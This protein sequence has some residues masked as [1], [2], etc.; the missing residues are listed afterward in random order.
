MAHPY[1][2]AVLS[3]RYHPVVVSSRTKPRIFVAIDEPHVALPKLYGAPA[4]ARPTPKVEPTPRP[5]DPDDL[6]I[7]AIR[8]DEEQHLA[9]AL[10]AYAFSGGGAQA[11]GRQGYATLLAAQGPELRPRPLSLRAIAGRLRGGD[12]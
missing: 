12:S 6:P 3:A 2:S 9:E 8:T 10:P 11:T 7:E 5:V 4:Y 1:Y